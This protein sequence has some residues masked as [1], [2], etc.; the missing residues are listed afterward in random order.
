VILSGLVFV[1]LWIMMFNAR[2]AEYFS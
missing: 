2:E 1:V